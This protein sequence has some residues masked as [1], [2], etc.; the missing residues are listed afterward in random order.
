MILIFLPAYKENPLYTDPFV[1]KYN[2][3][4]MYYLIREFPED[5]WIRN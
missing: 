3:S 4:N 1:F 2:D 5:Q